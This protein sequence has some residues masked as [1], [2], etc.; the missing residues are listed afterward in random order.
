[1][2]G[3]RPGDTGLLPSTFLVLALFWRSRLIGIKIL[4]IDLPVLAFLQ[5]SSWLFLQRPQHPLY[6]E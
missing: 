6:R 5:A 4:I 2:P 3:R 1:M